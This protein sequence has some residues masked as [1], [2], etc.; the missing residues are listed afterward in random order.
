MLLIGK[1]FKAEKER[2]YHL[3]EGRCLLCERELNEDI[4]S[5]HLDHDHELVGEEAGR[6]RGLLCPLCNALE[7]QIKHKFG[8]SGL[9]SK[10]V[11]ISEWL[12]NL[13]KYYQ[14]DTTQNN[15]H[16]QYVN[17]KA[18]WFTRLDKPD[19]L[20]ELSRIGITPEEKATKAQLSTLY[21]KELKKYLRTSHA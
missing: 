16:P 3:Q 8:R 6:V 19:M 1:Q 14:A 4:F 20:A 11:D 17:D 2:L 10:D 9:L 15:I 5:N 21:K 7:G 13:S 18:K 12:L